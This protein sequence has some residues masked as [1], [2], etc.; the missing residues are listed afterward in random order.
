MFQ[1]IFAIGFT[2]VYLGLIENRATLGHPHFLPR[3]HW[4]FAKAQALDQEAIPV[5]C[6]SGG[7]TAEGSFW[8]ETVVF[9]YDVF[10]FC[11]C[12]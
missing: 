5:T 8:K 7:E 3:G 1:T 9:Y 6:R 12:F 10:G 4:V 2:W 11:F